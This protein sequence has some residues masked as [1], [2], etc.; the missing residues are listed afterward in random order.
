MTRNGVRIRYLRRDYP[1]LALRTRQR[2]GWAWVSSPSS[3]RRLRVLTRP[4]PTAKLPATPTPSLLLGNAWLNA[5]WRNGDRLRYLRRDASCCSCHFQLQQVV[6][7][8]QSSLVSAV[9]HMCACARIRI[10]RTL[11][12]DST[13]IRVRLRTNQIARF[14]LLT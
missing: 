6:A 3:E 13:R 5:R 2:W 11:F 7:R 9:K 12:P 14:K 10:R 8:R 4:R 1:W